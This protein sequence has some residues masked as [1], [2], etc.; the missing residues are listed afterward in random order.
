[1]YV[2]EKRTGSQLTCTAPFLFIW[3]QRVSHVSSSEKKSRPAALRS[4]A[5][6]RIEER[7]EQR[8][9]LLGAGA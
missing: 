4:A 9:E 1:M 8:Q 3:E 6:R 5:A 7:V 2:A